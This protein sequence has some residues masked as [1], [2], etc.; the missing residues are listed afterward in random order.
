LLVLGQILQVW[1]DIRQVETDDVPGGSFTAHLVTSAPN[2]FCT[3]RA[4]VFHDASMVGV[5][6][7]SQV[8]TCFAP[9]S[10]LFVK[11][12]LSAGGSDSPENIFKK[13]GINPNK[14]LFETGLQRIK[15]NIDELERLWHRSKRIQ[16]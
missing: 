13:I 16:K 1:L 3:N 7:L 4:L 14:K 9:F 2:V 6:E 8:L 11:H 5:R 15:D 12:F 10:Q